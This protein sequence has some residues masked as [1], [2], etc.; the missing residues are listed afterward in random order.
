[1]KLV[2]RKT[3]PESRCLPAGVPRIAPYPWRIVQTPAHIFFLFE[4]NIHSYRQIFMDCR[5]HPADPDPSWYGHSIGHS[6]GHFEGKTLVVDTVGCNDL[7]WF[8]FK[9]QSHTERLH[10]QLG[11]SAVK[12]IP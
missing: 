7:S 9:G 12:L 1:L 8:D 10:T 5:S 6:I 3:I 4:G 11:L 2:F